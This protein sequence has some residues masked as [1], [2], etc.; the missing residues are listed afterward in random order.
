MGLGVWKYIQPRA[1]HLYILIY[2]VQGYIWEIL[3]GI[4]NYI[5]MFIG[6]LSD[7]IIYILTQDIKSWHIHIITRKIIKTKQKYMKQWRTK[8][9]RLN[10]LIKDYMLDNYK[11]KDYEVKKPS[12]HPEI[13]KRPYGY[14]KW[15]RAKIARRRCI[16]FIQQM[17]NTIEVRSTRK[18]SKPIM[19]FDSDSYDILVD[20][21]CSQSITS[22]LQDFIKPPTLSDMRISG[23]NGHTTQTKV[24]TVKW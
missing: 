15:R 19:H 18:K 11:V 5:L 8:L 9:A 14:H 6:I 13:T 7:I 23:F 21:C 17:H 12:P 20:K 1:A 24:G 2:T 16:K 10:R 4:I 3:K 22:S